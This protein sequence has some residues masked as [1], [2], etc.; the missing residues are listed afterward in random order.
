VTHFAIPHH[1]MYYLYSHQ[2]NGLTSGEHES[3]ASA[4]LCL[5]K[6]TADR[7]KDLG[8]FLELFLIFYNSF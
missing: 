6:C 4:V 1:L 8:R 3:A 5:P 2:I 7:D